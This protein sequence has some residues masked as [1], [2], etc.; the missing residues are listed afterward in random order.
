MVFHT[1]SSP[2]LGIMTGVMV[3]SS[4]FEEGLMSVE[5][6]ALSPQDY[7]SLVKNPIYRMIGFV[8]DSSLLSF[9]KLKLNFCTA[10]SDAT[11]IQILLEINQF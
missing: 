1:G 3:A 2:T 8:G 4:R 11:R 6:K 7:P 10:Y 9:H 5:S